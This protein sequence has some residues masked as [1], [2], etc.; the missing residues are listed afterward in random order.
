L[1]CRIKLIQKTDL[2]GLRCGETGLEGGKLNVE[3]QV[4][5]I[6]VRCKCLRDMTA[7]PTQRKGTG[8]V[9]PVD[10]IEVKNA[11]K[12]ILGVMRERLGDVLGGRPRYRNAGTSLGQRRLRL[13]L[14]R[15]LPR[16]R[17]RFLRPCLVVSTAWWRG[18]ICR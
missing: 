5:E 10:A 15:L 13:P 17:D 16:I 11:R 1:D 3:T 14:L 9:L 18:L 7:F 4:G 6:K 2:A 12:L 8:L